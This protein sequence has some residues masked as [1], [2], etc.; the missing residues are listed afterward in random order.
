MAGQ[1]TTWRDN[2]CNAPTRFSNLKREMKMMSKFFGGFLK[3][4]LIIGAVAT[5]TMA[6]AE[7]TK[8]LS[9]TTVVLTHGAF[10]DGSSWSRVIPVLEAKG[11]H[12]VAVQN[13]LSSL[14]DDV[15]AT[16][17]VVDE[18]P[19]RVVLVG[20]SWAGVVISEA[21]ND[22]KVKALVYVSAFAPDANQSIAD[23][24]KDLPAP[25]WSKELHK[26]S[27]GYLTLSDK[28][29]R[30]FF[31]PD[32]PLAGQRIV[33]A[34]QGPWYAG[35]LDE[36]VTHPAWR[37]RPSYFVVSTEDQMIAPALQERMAKAIGA[38][39]TRVHGSHV[40]LVSHPQAVAN[41][42]IEAAQRAQ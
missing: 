27:A 15:A 9:N 26:D 35:C 28:A 36:K 4:M 37:D 34:T 22:D 38:T 12:V 7:G 10:A 33:A 5:G 40:S 17:R 1:G 16:K 2:R 13:P 14:N 32:L 8:D 11:L 18:Q 39:V 23:I 6:H 24:T 19:G 21:G 3:S 29:I 42:I 41:A 30:Q 25:P 31:A 20:H